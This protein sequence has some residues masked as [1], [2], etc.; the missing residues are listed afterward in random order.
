MA[1]NRENPDLIAAR[2]VINQ[3][4]EETH[5]LRELLTEAYFKIA[6]L[7]ETD[8]HASQPSEPPDMGSIRLTDVRASASQVNIGAGCLE[9]AGRR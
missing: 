2:A 5:E 9:V 7:E 8:I 6:L 3:L 4:R 1:E